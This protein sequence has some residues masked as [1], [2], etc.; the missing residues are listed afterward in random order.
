MTWT[1][2]HDACEHQDIEAVLQLIEANSDEAVNVDDHGETPLHI[3]CWA[4]P[5]LKVVEALIAAFPQ[6]VTDQDAHGDTPLHVALTNPET[7]C[8]V[9]HA[10]LKACPAVASIAN[11][12]GLCPLHKACRHCPDEKVIEVLLEEYP[13]ALRN[14]I[15]VST[16]LCSGNSLLP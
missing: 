1:A 9:V 15:K 10:L 3:A 4:N 6:A 16:Y 7:S 5:P 12:E 2:L 13:Y 11:K 14:P 8:E